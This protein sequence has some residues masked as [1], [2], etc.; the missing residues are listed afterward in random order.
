MS[1]GTQY[2]V[3]VHTIKREH[4]EE[5]VYH[6]EC[7]E[8]E[9]SAQRDHVLSMCQCSFISLI[10]CSGECDHQST[11]SFCSSSSPFLF[12]FPLTSTTTVFYLLLCAFRRSHSFAQLNYCCFF[13]YLHSV[14]CKKLMSSHL[15]KPKIAV[16]GGGIV[17]MTTAHMLL[18]YYS[19]QLDSVTIISEEWSP[20]TTG[21]VSAG[22]IYP[23]LVGKQ[24]NACLLE[25]LFAKSMTHLSQLLR[26]AEAGKLGLSLCTVYEL[27]RDEADRK[28]HELSQTM[29]EHLPS[30]QDMSEKELSL[31][32][33]NSNTPLWT[34]GKM[35]TTYM[36]EPAQFLPYLREQFIAMVC[37]CVIIYL[38]HVL[39]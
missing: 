36:L 6:L 10:A 30:Y 22:Y 24:P 27:Y 33:G 18:D 31:F 14:D 28:A 15:R 17:G 8:K 25:T 13:C 39:I 9:I 11:S 34:S 38:V 19:S 3:R 32:Q 2:L 1:C 37:V 23:Y 35:I 12:S 20:D 7:R 5:L 4:A 16:V 26:S 21:D 29:A